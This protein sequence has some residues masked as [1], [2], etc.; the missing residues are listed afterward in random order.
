MK[1]PLTAKQRAFVDEY[2][3]NG[4]NASQA[5]KKAYPNCKSGWNAHGAKN[6]AKGSIKQAISVKTAKRQE[7]VEYNY[8]KAISELNKII[9]NLTKQ[10][11]SGN[12]SANSALIQVLREKNDIT[13]LHKQRFIDETEQKRELTETEQAEAR[14]LANIRLRQDIA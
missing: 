8:E 9:D 4:G 1:R 10:A 5:Y 12:I 2:C 6:V 14:R 7:K 3:S 13:G 11:R